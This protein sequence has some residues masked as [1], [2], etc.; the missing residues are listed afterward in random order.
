MEAEAVGDGEVVVVV[1]VELVG[2][3]EV[4]VVVVGELVGDTVGDVKE[5]VDV[6]VG[7]ELAVGDDVG[8]GFHRAFFIFTFRC[9][10]IFLPATNFPFCR[11]NSSEI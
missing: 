9:L 8:F 2:D 6:G 10:M 3:G 11:I 5:P 7:D 4:V 1:V